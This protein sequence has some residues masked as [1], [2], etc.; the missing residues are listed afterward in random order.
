MSGYKACS[1]EK[2]H[3]FTL[4]VCMCVCVLLLLVVVVVVVVVVAVVGCVFFRGVGG[5]G[6]DL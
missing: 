6:D 2:E 4:C 1:S 5:D 3:V